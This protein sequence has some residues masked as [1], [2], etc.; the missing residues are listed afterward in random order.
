[1]DFATLAGIFGGLYLIIFWGIGAPSKI[2]MFVDVPSL[3]I[4]M[5]GTMAAVLVAYPMSTVLSA[6]SVAKHAFLPQKQNP[7]KVVSQMAS[8]AEQARREGIL[9]LENRVPEIQDDFLRKGLELAVDGTDPQVIREVLDFEL[10]GLELRHRAGLQFFE[11][12][13]ALA[14]A[15][16]MIG[17]LIGLVLMLGNLSDPS[18]IG[19]AMAVALITTFYGALF[20]NL[21]CIPIAIKLRGLHEAEIQN[22]QMILEGILSLQRGENPRLIEAKLKAHLSPEARIR[23]AKN[24]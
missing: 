23:G 14:P 7:A 10:D 12:M 21:F 16:G 2:A 22:R 9:S 20:A 17:T 4:T 6:F 1:M 24:G 15:F 18:S 13:G 5:G 3:A 11:D 19:P 8:F